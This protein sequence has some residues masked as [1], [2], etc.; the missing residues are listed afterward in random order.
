MFSY[1]PAYTTQVLRLIIAYNLSPFLIVDQSLYQLDMDVLIGQRLK[2]SVVQTTENKGC[3]YRNI[4]MECYQIKECMPD[5]NN[6][7]YTWEY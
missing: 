1:F 6:P 3:L 7:F 2:L 4:G 5:I